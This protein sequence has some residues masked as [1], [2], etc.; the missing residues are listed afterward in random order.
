MKPV[1]GI[2]TRPVLSDEN[3]QM[4]GVYKEVALAVT[5]AGGIPI[6]IINWENLL[7]S[8]ELFDGLIFQGGDNFT[9]EEKKFIKIAYD[10]NIKTLGI[11]L[12]MQL[13]GTMLNGTIKNI[14]NH[15]YQNKNYVHNVKISKN[16]T[17]YKVFK[18]DIIKVNSRHNSCLDSTSLEVTGI[19]EDGIIEMIEDRSKDFFVG[20]QWHPESMVTYDILQQDLFNYFVNKCGDKL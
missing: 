4:L 1:I 5:K 16:S 18:D 19:S 2:V 14:E 8:I 7:E 9:D 13:M 20:V 17:L 15:K 6:G 3:K 12:G 11:C 10:N